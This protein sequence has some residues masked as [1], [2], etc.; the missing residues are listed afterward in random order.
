MALTYQFNDLVGCVIQCKS[1]QTGLLVG[2]YHN[3]QAGMD[4]SGGTWSTVCESHGQLVSHETLALARHHAV[5]PLGWCEVCKG[6]EANHAAS[7]Q[8]D[9]ATIG[10][11]IILDEAH[12]FM[13]PLIKK[14][15]SKWPPYFNKGN[16]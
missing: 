13:E 7:D 12:R 3:E 16:S 8:A 15:V 2:I 5:D 10:K 11:L 9:P 14:Q 6:N 4:A 1:R